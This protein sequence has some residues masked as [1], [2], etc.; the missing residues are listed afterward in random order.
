MTATLDAYDA[1]TL[2]L[3]EWAVGL[4]SA[5]LTHGDRDA[6]V[7]HHLDSVGC[8]IGALEA[9]V[10]RA[11]RRLAATAS[12]ATGG[13]SVVG[14][15]GR[16]APEQAALANATMVRYLD[17]ND[18]YLRL[19]GGHTSDFIPA[20]WAAAELRGASGADLLLGLHAGYETFAALADAVPLRDRGWDYRC[21][22]PSPRRSAPPS[23][24]SSGSSRSRT[25]LPWP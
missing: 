24:W 3:A 2:H 5:S 16:V 9:E 6:L 19:G 20:V 10:C 17:F 8:A 11:V 23:S 18:N 15:P 12:T 1:T 21:S 22:S 14:M 13:A 7:W 4:R 25:P